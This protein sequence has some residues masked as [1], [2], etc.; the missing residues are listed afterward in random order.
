MKARETILNRIKGIG[1]ASI[2]LQE[3]ELKQTDAGNYLPEFIVSLRNAGA[4]VVQ[5]AEHENASDFVK[6]NFPGTISF[7][8]IESWKK[9]GS[10]STLSMLDKLESVFIEGQIAVAENGAIWVSDRW[11]PNRIIPFITRRLILKI[12]VN[13]LVPTMHQAYTRIDW[14]ELSYGVFIAGPSKTA[15][16]EQSLVIGAHGPKSLT[17]LI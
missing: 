6:E 12:S 2:Q 11:F 5:L 3:L 4:E 9:Y 14:S 16:I 10:G 1:L 17:V 7:E 15:D 13:D 8:S